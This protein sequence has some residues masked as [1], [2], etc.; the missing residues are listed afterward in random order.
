MKFLIQ[1][2]YVWYL[3]ILTM[4]KFKNILSNYS[5]TNKLKWAR[6]RWIEMDHTNKL[7]GIKFP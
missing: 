2:F 5:Y 6:E 1:T 3:N 4:V 7:S